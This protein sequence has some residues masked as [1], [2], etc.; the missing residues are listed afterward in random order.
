MGKRCRPTLTAF[1]PTTLSQVQEGV[2]IFEGKALVGTWE[3]RAVSPF[4]WIAAH[5]L[6]KELE[7]G[8]LHRGRVLH[9]GW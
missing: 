7:P 3:V 1:I 4:F 9:E 8:K 6:S 5:S 2:K